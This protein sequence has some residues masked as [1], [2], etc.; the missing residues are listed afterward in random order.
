MEYKVEKA[1][2]LCIIASL[3]IAF[4]LTC[5]FWGAWLAVLLVWLG[6][7]PGMLLLSMIVGFIMQALGVKIRVQ[8]TV[9]FSDENLKNLEHAERVVGFYKDA[10]IYEWIEIKHPDT[11]EPIRLFFDGT[12]D[13]EEQIYE[14]PTTRWFLMVSPG[15]IYLEPKSTSLVE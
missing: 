5:Y 13:L 3:A 2:S 7:I 6:V 12:I 10:E 4:A 9:A 8:R 15:I 14:P 1:A 11:A